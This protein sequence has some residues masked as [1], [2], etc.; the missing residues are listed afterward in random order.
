VTPAGHGAALPREPR[1]KLAA[2]RGVPDE[3]AYLYELIQTIGS[4]P[5]L[6]SI[7][8]GV[9]RLVTEATG[10]HACFIYFLE[11]DG[12][13]LRA[14]S[15]MYESLEGKVRIPLGEGLTGWVASTRRPTFIKE[16]ALEDPRVRR[17]YFPELGDEVYQSLVSVPMFSRSG[18]VIGVITLHADAPHEFTRDDL[19]FLEHTASL[20]GGAVENA[21]LY[22]EATERV[23]T[24][25]DLSRLSQRIASARGVDSVLAAVTAGTA[26]L[27]R[28]ER[29]EIYLLDGEARPRRAAAFPHG[30]KGSPIGTNASALL[31]RATERLPLSSQES[32]TLA[33]SLWGEHTSGVALFAPLIAGDE[34]LGVLAVLSRGSVPDVDATLNALAAHAAVAI[35]QHQ[36]IEWL[37]ERNLVKDLFLALSR[38]DGPSPEVSE[39]A[40]RLGCD[41]D[42]PHLVLH[43]VPWPSS[44]RPL[45]RDGRAD[46][47]RR[48]ARPPSWSDTSGRMEARLQARFP[49][50][51]FDRLERS[52]RALIP[53]GESEEG[54]LEALSGVRAL[55]WSD[56]EADGGL[57]AGTSDPCRGALAFAHGFEEAT[58]AADVGGLIRGAPG[59]TSYQEL[60]SYRYVLQAATERDPFQA[61][62]ELLVDYD[63]KRD[64]QLLDTLE[65]YLDRRGNVVATS[66]DLY[67]HPNTLRQRLAR[68][69]R[70]SGLDLEADDWLSL[71]VATKAVK[72]RRMRKNAEQEGG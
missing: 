72:F 56:G 71:A 13:E 61:R 27:L 4:G 28:A 55:D 34:R 49:G 65:A 68:I 16:N 1:T 24:L 29:C 39:L 11:G 8:R 14:A 26:G 17:A 33:T 9:V 47:A 66:R 64:T 70:V 3:R 15:L 60:G 31:V 7:L 36:V 25:S 59:V 46:G 51:L 54:F 44:S 19:D 5:D 45:R 37:R 35:R 23:A 67:V 63:A 12:L 58:A 62:V 42:S 6:P 41:L 10:C 43:A 20:I 32:V 40:D 30:G 57:S 69:E 2:V 48:A 21:R 18:E 52:F 38:Q 50:V 53:I 22:E